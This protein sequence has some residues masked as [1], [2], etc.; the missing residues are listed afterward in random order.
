MDIMV[1]EGEE[2]ATNS[3]YDYKNK[4]VNQMVIEKTK[5][6]TYSIT[7]HANDH[8]PYIIE[9]NANPNQIANIKKS[10]FTDVSLK[11]NEQFNLLYEN[12]IN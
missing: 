3:Q 2:R 12:Y 7:L 10:H 9:V 5:N 11:Q 8:C 6:I 4:S 1:R